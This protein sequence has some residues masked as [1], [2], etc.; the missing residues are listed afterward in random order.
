MILTTKQ[1]LGFGSML[2]TLGG[3]GILIS[4]LLGWTG[5]GGSGDFLFGFLFGLCMGLG[6]GLALFGLIEW[7]SA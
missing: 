1:K 4:S 3:L 2:A 7:R 6:A 5:A